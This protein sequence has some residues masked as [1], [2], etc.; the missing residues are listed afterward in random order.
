MVDGGEFLSLAEQSLLT[1]LNKCEVINP[2][3]PIIAH[4]VI[5]RPSPIRILDVSSLSFSLVPWSVPP[6]KQCESI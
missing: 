6:Q 3:G 5:A 1:T 4:E 2:A